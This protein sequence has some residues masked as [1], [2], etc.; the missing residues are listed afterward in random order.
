MWMAA[1]PKNTP[2]DLASLKESMETTRHLDRMEMLITLYWSEFDPY[3]CRLKAIRDRGVEI[4][5]R[6][7]NMSG[8]RDD[9]VFDAVIALMKEMD[10]L[11]AEFVA[12]AKNSVAP[13][14]RAG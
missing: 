13:L 14:A 10:A 7:G 6:T 1:L 12:V 11:G 4:S 3:L 2:E 5:F 9:Q 8:L